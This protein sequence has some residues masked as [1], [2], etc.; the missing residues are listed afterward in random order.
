MTAAAYQTGFGNHFS[1]E[2]E[3]GALPRQQNSPQ[4]CPI[5]L[6]AEQLSGTAFTNPRLQN[7]KSWLYRILPSVKHTHQFTPY[8]QPHLISAEHNPTKTPPTALRWQPLSLPTTPTHFIDGWQTMVTNGSSSNHQGGT[9]SHYVANTNMT[10]CFFYNAD[11]DLLIVPELGG[12][13]IKTEMGVLEVEPNMLA[14]IPR[15]IRF[16]V[17]LTGDIARGYICETHGMP[18]QLPDRGPIG[19][20][21]L[22]EEHHFEY[23]VAAYEDHRGEFTQIVKFMG[24][25]W[26]S[27]IEQSPLDVVAWRGNYAPYR[28]DL[29]H[30]NPAWS[31]GWDHSDPSIFTVLTSPSARPGTA[32]IDFVIFPTRWM[33]SEHSFRPPY[34]HRN[35]MSEYMGM[36]HGQYDAKET[37]F[38]PGGASLHNCM[39]P[40]G[41]DSDSYHNAIKE[42]LK[43]HKYDETLA[44]M[45]ESSLFWQVTEF[46]LNSS[47]LETNYLDCWSGLAKQFTL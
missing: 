16:Q 41:P 21:G 7:H 24:Q 22:A 11:G 28:Y 37:G 34:Y 38:I 47:S 12:L 36:I 46:A 43:P 42:E 35:I 3:K 9:V 31:V 44:I 5:G 40:H 4:H 29:R 25:C 6:Y 14:V 20:N 1:T 39:T 15:G 13:R 8:K 27:P 2:A 19:A 23:P 26:Q 18:F 10:D 17:D 33:V 32:N 45:F 30:F